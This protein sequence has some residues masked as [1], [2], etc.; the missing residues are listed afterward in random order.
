MTTKVTHGVTSFNTGQVI[1]STYSEYTTNASLTTALPVDDTI[2]QITEGTEIVTASI[3]PK[4]ATSFIRVR[5][6]GQATLNGPDEHM[7]VA[8]FMDAVSNAIA[9]DASTVDKAGYGH[10]LTIEYREAASSV[11]ART[12]RIRAGSH[13]GTAMRFNGNN[14]ARFFGGTSRATLV[15]EEVAA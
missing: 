8:L 11:T 2:P 12:Y 3:T 9:A 14:A 4:Y 6:Q 13:S 1:Q 5:F 15:V 10:T 7:A